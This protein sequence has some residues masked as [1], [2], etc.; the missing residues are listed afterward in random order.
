MRFFTSF[1]MV[2]LLSITLF[3]QNAPIDFEPGGFGAE[4]T[5]TVF[6]NETNPP[7]EIIA[8]PDPSGI[9]TSANVASFTALQAGNPWAGCESMRGADIGS[10]VWDENNTT[11]KIMVWK[12]VVSDVGL[13]FASATGWAQ[14]ELKVPNT[15]VN[16]WE[17]LTFD[18]S[19]YLNPPPDE[20]G[21]LV[22]IIVFPDFDLNGRTQDNIVYFDNITFGDQIADPEPMTA[23]PTPTREAPTVISLFSDAYDDV[24]VDTW[25]TNWSAA[26]LED[27][28]IQGNPTKKYTNLDFVGIETVANQ[29]DINGMTHF[30]VDVWSPDFEWFRVVLVDFGPNGQFGGGDDTE[31]IVDTDMP[32]RGAWLSIDIPLS[33]FQGLANKQNFAQLI[34][35]ARPVANTTLYVD[36]V[37][38][39]NDMSNVEDNL[40]DAE[41]VKM[42]PNPVRAGDMIQFDGNVT[43]LEILDMTGKLVLSSNRNFIY[44]TGLTPGMYMVS[45]KTEDNKQQIQK[46]IIQ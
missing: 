29:I 17:E 7:L 20:G 41:L 6:E 26:T 3:A 13:K 44:T 2:V 10:F 12:S 24:P 21:Q 11:I 40:R 33:D 15:L 37:Y 23:A 9:N 4:W 1:C 25:R 31:G 32:E 38:F 43:Q 30:H 14:V 18:F 19:D 5:W 46:L 34:F 16:Q 27:I 35:A 39:F 45:I 22:Q 28:E 42:Y 36:N 8:N